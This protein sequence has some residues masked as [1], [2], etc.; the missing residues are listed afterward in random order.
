[1]VTTVTGSPASEVASTLNYVRMRTCYDAA[2]AVVANCTPMSSVRKIVVHLTANGTRSGQHTTTGGTTDTWTGAVH[3]T[4]DDTVARVFTTAVP[5]VETSRIHSAVTLGRDTTTF[6]SAQSSRVTTEAAN[7]SIKLV[8]WNLPRSANPYPAS[9]K[10]VRVVNVHVVATKGTK[11]ET[12]DVKRTV[13]VTFPPDAQGNVVMKVNDKTCNLNLV[14]HA[15]TN[16][17]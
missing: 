14:T 2:G 9:G 7:D 11:T 16:C 6:T 15:V 13:E 10:I 12:R 1:M 5:P 4:T 8:T 17:H 3:R